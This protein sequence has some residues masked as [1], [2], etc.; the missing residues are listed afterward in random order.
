[1]KHRIVICMG[2]SCFARGNEKNIRLIREFIRRNALETS[3]ELVGARC[4]GD[5]SKGPNI[6]IDGETYNRMDQEAFID[7]LKRKLL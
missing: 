3:V 4:A 2:S 6:V 7:V 5:C 1:M